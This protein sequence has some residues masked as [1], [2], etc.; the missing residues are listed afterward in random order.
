[1]GEFEMKRRYDEKGYKITIYGLLSEKYFLESKFILIQTYSYHSS[2]CK[3]TS[4]D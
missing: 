3:K 2:T 4:E 1:M